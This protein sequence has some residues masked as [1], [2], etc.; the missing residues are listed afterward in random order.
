[1]GYTI[2][3]QLQ[4]STLDTEQ[5][6]EYPWGCGVAYCNGGC[7]A[8]MYAM[9]GSQNT[10]PVVVWDRVIYRIELFY[11]LN[12]LKAGCKDSN[13]TV[14]ISFA[15]MQTLGTAKHAHSYLWI[16]KCFIFNMYFK[17]NN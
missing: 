11:C 15:H 9:L 3:N 16:N 4:V 6:Y 14:M 1:M 17:Q 8:Y 10:A 7:D 2:I 12:I 5:Y 13:F